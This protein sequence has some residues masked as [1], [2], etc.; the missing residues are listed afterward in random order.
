MTKFKEYFQRMV[1]SNKEVFEKFKIIHDEYA[2]NPDANQEKYNEKG[3]EIIDKTENAKEG[4][5]NAYED[6]EEW[7][8]KT[9]NPKKYQRDNSKSVNAFHAARHISEKDFNSNTM[10]YLREL[11]NNL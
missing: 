3:K 9:F 11:I 6:V 5:G 7:T 2:L 10:K 4:I 8:K 1:D